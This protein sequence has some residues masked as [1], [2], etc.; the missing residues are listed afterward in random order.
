MFVEQIHRFCDE[1]ELPHDM[2][3]LGGDHL[4]PLPWSDLP[5]AEAMDKAEV[6]VRMS[7]RAGFK[8]IHLDTTMKLGDDPQDSLDE[9]VIATRAARLY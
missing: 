1:N 6:L 8:K 7:V 9:E 5:A 2:V 3:I 4:G